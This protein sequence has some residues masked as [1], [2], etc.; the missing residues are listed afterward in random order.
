MKGPAAGCPRPLETVR[1]V[2]PPK[3]RGFRPS[4]GRKDEESGAVRATRPAAHPGLGSTTAGRS[5]SSPKSPQGMGPRTEAACSLP[6]PQRPATKRLGAPPSPP[7]LRGPRSL[8]PEAPGHRSPGERARLQPKG[9]VLGRLGQDFGPRRIQTGQAGEFFDNVT[10]SS[11]QYPPG[12][13]R[14]LED[15]DRWLVASGQGDRQAFRRLFEAS[16]PRVLALLKRWLHSR[17]DAE[18]LLGE[19]FFKAWH[20]AARF[21]PSRGSALGWIGVIA[22]RHALDHRRQERRRGDR[23]ANFASLRAAELGGTGCSREAPRGTP[24]PDPNGQGDPRPAGAESRTRP[25]LAGSIGP[26]AALLVSRSA[27]DPA[28]VSARQELEARLHAVVA[29]L[30]S[31][32][33]QVV[34]VVFFEGLSHSAAAL[35]LG[36]PLGTI[37]SRIRSALEQLRLHAAIASEFQP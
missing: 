2:P 33:Q 20:A 14:P 15:L 32:Q 21:D 1:E 37:K 3:G 4:M 9:V 26:G 7:A 8:L 12:V 13:D 5:H 28:Q 29:S 16:A 25:D 34:Q 35:R 11:E 22:Q 10:Q 24:R 19:V 6:A 23:E 36:V 30:S 31:E 18:E 27:E 17:R